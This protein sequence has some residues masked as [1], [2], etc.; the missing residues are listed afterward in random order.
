M[1]SALGSWRPARINTFVLSNLRLMSTINPYTI[2]SYHI[3]LKV[4]GQNAFKLNDD[5]P[6][7]VLIELVGR[8]PGRAGKLI[9][10]RSG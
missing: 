4:L 1:R 9:Q 2:L 7:W 6:L 8:V 5:V 10:A 3:L